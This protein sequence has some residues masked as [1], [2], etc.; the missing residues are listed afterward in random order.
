MRLFRNTQGF[1]LIELMIVI[2]IIGILASIS[3]PQYQQYTHR[4]QIAEALSL[5]SDIESQVNSYYK[6]R[7]KFPANNAQAGL[8]PADKI[9]GNYITS[10]EVENGAIH[11]TLGNRVFNT[12][13]G[14][15]LTIQPIVVK[16]SPM[17]PISFSCGYAGAPKGMETVG[18]NKTNIEKYTLPSACREY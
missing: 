10:M 3:I 18:K 2:S 11:T 9:I 13:K 15:I 16:G 7:G 17:S 8:P 12:L 1:T 6:D 5:V 14:K 4:A